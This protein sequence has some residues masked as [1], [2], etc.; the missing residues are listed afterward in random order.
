MMFDWMVPA[1]LTIVTAA[2]PLVFAAVGETVAE[3]AG[4]RD[5]SPHDLR[6]TA[7]SNMTAAGIPRL[8]V[9][10]L[11][12]H[13]DGSVGSSDRMRGDWDICLGW[14]LVPQ[15]RLLCGFRMGS[16]WHLPR[17]TYR[18]RARTDRGA[19]RRYRRRYMSDLGDNLATT[20]GPE[21]RLNQ[22][23]QFL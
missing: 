17:R 7:A 1:F 9:D 12:N 3:K 11:L 23:T 4:V 16:D 14:H 18:D 6:R 2:T 19:Q 10:Q 22:V 20:A 8:H 15:R 5:F 13:V 21:H